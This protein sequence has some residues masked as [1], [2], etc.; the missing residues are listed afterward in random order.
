MEV[1]W[2]S[3]CELG[4]TLHPSSTRRLLRDGLGAWG[5]QRASWTRA[6]LNSVTK[7]CI[8]IHLS[9]SGCEPGRWGRI[10]IA[11]LRDFVPN[12]GKNLARMKQCF[13]LKWHLWFSAQFVIPVPLPDVT[14]LERN[15]CGC[16]GSGSYLVHENTPRIWNDFSCWQ[17]VEEVN[18]LL[19]FFSFIFLMWT[20]FEVFIEFVAKL[21]LFY[22]LS[23][24]PWGMC[25]LSSLT[26]DGTSTL[27]IGEWCFHHWTTRE[28]L[29]IS[30]LKRA[31]S[32]C[33][34]GT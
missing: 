6:E 23:V 29:A 7:T 24:W 2:A 30:F 9:V 25:D 13:G 18:Q 11:D 20:I 31:R 1:T 16:L 5:D 3:S 15:T 32:S 26:K 17:L 28:V 33:D 10:W 27:C 19:L 21:F 14:L 22:A 34:S 12:V 8:Y 4:E